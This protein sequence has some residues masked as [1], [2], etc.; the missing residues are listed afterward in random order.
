MPLRRSA[1]IAIVLGFLALGLWLVSGKKQEASRKPAQ[2]APKSASSIKPR[3][4]AE[5]MQEPNKPSKYA[6]VTIRHLMYEPHIY[7][8]IDFSRA[9]VEAFLERHGRTTGNLLAASRL[10]HDLSFLREAVKADP[11]SRAAQL[12]LAF[13]GESAAEKADALAAFR[14]LEPDNVLGDYLAAHQAFE[15]GDAGAA[16]VALAKSLDSPVYANWKAETR[17]GMEFAYRDAGYEPIPAKFIGEYSSLFPEIYQMNNVTDRLM[18]LHGEFIRSADFDAADPT[19]ALALSIGRRLQDQSPYESMHGIGIE[20]RVLQQLDPS[21][22]VGPGGQ[23]AA[24]RLDELL[25]KDQELKSFWREE[26]RLG[27]VDAA[28]QSQFLDKK[29]TEGELAAFKWF[30]EQK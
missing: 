13:I 10:L 2:V 29:R 9:E 19:L 1:Q 7:H 22:A 4:A 26:I 15:S 3:S 18:E 16:A 20:R 30:R 14:T 5:I 8:K 21:L 17:V 11:G 6:V 12:Q 24:A 25:A 28:T 27:S 23:T